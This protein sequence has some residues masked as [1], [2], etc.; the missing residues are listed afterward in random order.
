MNYNPNDKDNVRQAVLS[1]MFEVSGY[2][3]T[4]R[5]L[6]Q[7]LKQNPNAAANINADKAFMKHKFSAKKLEPAKVVPKAEPAKVEA[8]VE[9]KQPEPIAP[10]SLPPAPAPLKKNKRIGT[11]EQVYFGEAEKTSGGLTK[12]DLILN[13]KSGKVISKKKSEY[14]QK[15]AAERLKNYQANKKAN[16]AQQ[17]AAA[18]PEPAAPEEEPE[19]E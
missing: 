1:A 12:N 11:K 17:Q 14:G 18:N 3:A 6:N 2:N 7:Q 16:A 15:Y 13:A 10:A 5:Q 8:K 9:E 19:E 4:I